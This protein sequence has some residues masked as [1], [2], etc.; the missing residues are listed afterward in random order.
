MDQRYNVAFSSNTK[1][2]FIVALRIACFSI[3]FSSSERLL[4][5]CTYFLLAS[6]KVQYNYLER[7][8]LGNDAK[9]LRT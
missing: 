3:S 1:L 5:F 4:L 8:W 7:N 9:V 6:R 2:V